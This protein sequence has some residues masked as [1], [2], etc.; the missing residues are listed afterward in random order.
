MINN[1]HKSDMTTSNEQKGGASLKAPYILMLCFCIVNYDILRNLKE[2]L[3]IPRFGAEAIP[4]VKFWGG[5]PVAFAFVV[6]YSL[7][8][9]RLNKRHLFICTLLPFLIW[10]P[11]FSHFIF[12]NLDYFSAT[13]LSK[14]LEEWL[15]ESLLVISSLVRDWPITVFH[16]TSE[17]WGTAVLCTLFWTSVNDVF[18]TE[19]AKSFYPLLTIVGNA[20]SIFS[21]ALTVYLITSQPHWQA[22]LDIFSAVFVVMGFAI[23]LLHD[24]SYK[25]RQKNTPCF[26]AGEKN[27]TTSL[28][29]RK[30]VSYLLT[31]PYL[32]FMALIMLSYSI[33]INLI[34]VAWKNQL[35][36]LY[37]T[38]HEYAQFMGKLTSLYGVACVFSGVLLSL[39]I[40]KG[41][42]AAAIVTPLIMV[43]TGLP[44]FLF[45]LMDPQFM[46]FFSVEHHNVLL[47][48]TSLG[49]LSVVFSKSA[50]YTFFDATKEMAFVPLNDEQKYKGKAAIELIVSRL[51]KSGS[52]FIIQFLIFF[53]GSLSFALTWMAGIFLVVAALW[54]YSIYQLNKQYSKRAKVSPLKNKVL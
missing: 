45:S 32:G 46:R 5:L 48:G 54:M 33:S 17:L 52:S 43:L 7:L 21:G 30:S 34:E 41:W 10:V 9:N 22:S 36:Q 35:V 29:F 18:T 24:Y 44:F 19:S 6:T 38:E 26:I 28:P 40:R 53:F 50:K 14:T 51:G 27:K 39:L 16:A 12:P 1:N 42:M 37:P 25:V 15:P 8:A 13:E 20:S 3:L 31:S 23:L 4:F 11:L 2:S 49:M 47:I